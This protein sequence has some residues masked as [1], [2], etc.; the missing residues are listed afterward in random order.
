MDPNDTRINQEMNSDYLV[1]WFDDLGSGNEEFNFLSNFYEG[2]PLTLPGVTWENL[3]EACGVAEDKRALDLTGSIQFLTGEHAFAAMKFW[4]T[5]WTHFEDIVNAKGYA[6]V[7]PKGHIVRSAPSQAKALGRSR[8]HPLR[9]DWEI[10]KLDV[11]AA[12]IRAKFAPG[13]DE[14]ERLLATGTRMLVEG[15][16]WGDDVWGVDIDQT[17]HLPRG[18]N[19]LGTLLMARRAELASLLYAGDSDD[20]VHYFATDTVFWNSNFSRERQ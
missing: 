3:F 2:E 1:L 19:W 20:R 16:Y 12:V 17:E 13:R 9:P 14:A 6:Y 10:V 7:S 15:T 4:G 8:E 18:R 5:D 11:M